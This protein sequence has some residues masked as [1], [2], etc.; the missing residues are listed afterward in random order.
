MSLKLYDCILDHWPTVRIPVTLPESAEEVLSLVE[1]AYL[2]GLPE[3]M[4]GDDPSE[5]ELL[6]LRH[7][8]IRIEGLR[9][10]FK[11]DGA[12]WLRNNL[13]RMTREPESE[14]K[15]FKSAFPAIFASSG[16]LARFVSADAKAEYF[17]LY[18]LDSSMCDWSIKEVHPG[19]PE[20]PAEHKDW[21]AIRKQVG[22]HGTERPRT[23]PLAAGSAAK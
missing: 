2:D 10:V 14:P 18:H 6:A 11:A 7:E 12:A 23:A 20:P 13:P 3:K 15:D 1:D 4:L 16:F 17:R 19:D 8:T 21:T 9:S 22:T 5:A